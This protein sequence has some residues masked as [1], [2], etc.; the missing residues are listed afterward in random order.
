MANERNTTG[1]AFGSNGARLDEAVGAIE[2]LLSESSSRV[3]VSVMSIGVSSSSVWLG[4]R[5]A[6]KLLCVQA[7]LPRSR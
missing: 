5:V 1:S 4:E 2:G 7:R 6:G 3:M